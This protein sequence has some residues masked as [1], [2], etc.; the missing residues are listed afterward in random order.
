MTKAW[1]GNGCFVI[2]CS[3]QELSQPDCSQ[4]SIYLHFNKLL[5]SSLDFFM[6]ILTFTRVTIAPKVFT[7]LVQC[8]EN[9]YLAQRKKEQNFS[10]LSLDHPG[11]ELKSLYLILILFC[12]LSA[13]G[14]ISANNINIHYFINWSRKIFNL[15]LAFLGVSTWSWSVFSISLTMSEVARV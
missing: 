1:R 4:H 9:V 11:N 2:C 5:L 3:S 15:N 13:S 12:R 6:D 14:P 10:W 8:G 7:Y